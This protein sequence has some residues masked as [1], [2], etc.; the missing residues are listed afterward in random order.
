[1]RAGGARRLGALAGLAL[2]G[3]ALGA[4][5]CEKAAPP[6]AAAPEVLVTTVKGEDVPI[7]FE[8]LGTT[9]GNVDAQIRAQVSGYLQSRNY[10]EGT[11]VKAGQLLFQID[12]RQYQAAYDNA[13]GIVQRNEAEL[14]RDELDVARYTPLAREGAVSQ[15][16]L[17]DAVQS[18]AAN[19]AAVLASQAELEQ[20]RLNLEWTKV[21]SPVDGIASIANAQVG[22]LIQTQTVLASVSQVDPIVVIFLVSEQEYLS[23]A[24]TVRNPADPDASPDE[25]TKLQ[26]ILADGS[27]HPYEGHATIANLSADPRTGTIEIKGF[28]PNP[29]RILRPGLYAR[30]RGIQRVA[31]NA[32]VVPQRAV[33]ELQGTYQVAVVGADDTVTIKVVKPG[34]RVGSGWLIEEGLAPGDRVVVEGLQKVRNGMKVVAKPAE[35][36]PAGSKPGVEPAA[37]APASE[38]APRN[39]AAVQGPDGRA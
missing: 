4:V 2:A 9:Q 25:D 5:G 14:K 34:P 38:A 3:A 29:T 24:R 32:I 22:D 18:A 11:I 39:G 28:F 27:V 36:P 8:F 23:F 35:A 37:N 1:M 16:E 31:E 7:Y 33:S 20:A 26:L 19:R 10:K 30:V 15:R 12:P 6:Q 17:D 13:R 21:L